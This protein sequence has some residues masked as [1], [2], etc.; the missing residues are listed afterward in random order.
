M[1]GT[2][3]RDFQYF[4]SGRLVHVCFLSVH[5]HMKILPIILIPIHQG[6]INRYETLDM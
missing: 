4:Y 5:K 2:N 1:S 3:V 6:R